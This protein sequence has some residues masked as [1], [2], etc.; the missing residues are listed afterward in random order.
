MKT[1]TKVII[2]VVLVIGAIAAYKMYNK[3]EEPASEPNASKKVE[4]DSTDKASDKSTQKAAPK[5]PVAP[6]NSPKA[7]NKQQIRFRK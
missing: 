5:A 1:S 2:G 4:P 3:S 7:P 6:S